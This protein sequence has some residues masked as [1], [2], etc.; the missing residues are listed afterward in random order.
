MSSPI[1]PIRMINLPDTAQVSSAASGAGPGAFQSMLER[2]VGQV[3][4][5]QAQ[6]QQAVDGFLSGQNEE[7]HS[8]ALATQRADLQ[9]ELFM[10]VRNKA[11][12]AYQEIMRMQV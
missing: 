3:D 5:S 8:V 2:M 4:Q 1:S 9:F 10:Q 12:S 7:L 6:A 11:V